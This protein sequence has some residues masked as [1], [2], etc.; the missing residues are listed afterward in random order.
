MSEQN[1]RAGLVMIA[2]H[3]TG[4]RAERRPQAP[5]ESPLDVS[6]AP[7]KPSIDRKGSGMTVQTFSIAL[8]HE[9][10]VVYSLP[11]N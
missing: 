1:Q 4:H 7:L 8:L 2:G 10:S 3:A 5:C 11:R 6:L 9:E